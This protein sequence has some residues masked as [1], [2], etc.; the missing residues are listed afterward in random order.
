MLL[1]VR[2]TERLLVLLRRWDLGLLQLFLM[3]LSQLYEQS[4][5]LQLEFLLL[6]IVA[7]EAKHALF[8]LLARE[9]LGRQRRRVLVNRKLKCQILTK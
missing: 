7:Q 2:G 9:A 5:A 6:L 8:V 4:N 1:I 3:A